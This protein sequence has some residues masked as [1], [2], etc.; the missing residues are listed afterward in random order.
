[1]PRGGIRF[2][3]SR[4]P[5]GMD[6]TAAPLNIEPGKMALV[7]NY[8][9]SRGAYRS[10]SG[11][12][13]LNL[14][15]LP[16]SG[17][18]LNGVDQYVEVEESTASLEFKISLSNAFGAIDISFIAEKRDTTVGDIQWLYTYSTGAGTSVGV[19]TV[20]DASGFLQ[21]GLV[22]GASTLTSAMTAA[23]Q[24]KPGVGYRVVA[25]KE[26]DVNVLDWRLV[27][28]R[29]GEPD[30]IV[31]TSA[32]MVNESTGRT[33]V[34]G[35][36]LHVGAENFFK[37]I[38]QE[39]RHW[40]TQT[41]S[42]IDAAFE[43]TNETDNGRYY[44]DHELTEAEVVLFKASGMN[45]YFK[46]D[47]VNTQNRVVDLTLSSNDGLV[48]P[49]LPGRV[50]PGLVDNAPETF[51]VDISDR[52]GHYARLNERPA[53]VGSRLF[54]QLR[55]NTD[56]EFTI[57]MAI[58]L[59]KNRIDE[60]ALAS[61]A[62]GI[63]PLFY[64]GDE[65][66]NGLGRD[67]T[68]VGEWC[69]AIWLENIGTT[70]LPDYRVRLA[71]IDETNVRTEVFA[72]AHTV[73]LGVDYRIDVVRDGRY[74]WARQYK[75]GELLIAENGEELQADLGAAVG[76]R[77]LYTGTFTNGPVALV[78]VFDD[79]ATEFY[80]PMLFDDIRMYSVNAEK[81][82]AE[83]SITQHPWDKVQAPSTRM[84][85]HFLCNEPTGG[86]L[87]D[88][89]PYN[90]NL[91][92]P[93]GVEGELHKLLPANTPP[94]FGAGWVKANRYNRAAGLFG[95]K[96]IETH[97]EVVFAVA[98]GGIW[99]IS[100]SITGTTRRIT[101]IFHGLSGNQL[102]R[103]VHVANQA[104]FSDGLNPVLRYDGKSMGPIGIPAPT[105]APGLADGG[106]VGSGLLA[107]AYAYVFT[108]KNSK[109]GGRSNPSPSASL[110][111]IANTQVN[112][113]PFT[114]PNEDAY[115]A[116]DT[117]EIWRTQANSTRLYRLTEIGIANRDGI[118]A[119]A[120]AGVSG[121]VLAVYNDIARDSAIGN[122]L[123][124]GGA[125][126]TAFGVFPDCKYVVSARS[127]LV[128]IA[129]KGFPNR[130]VWCELGFPDHHDEAFQIT[131]DMD[132][133][134]GDKSTGGVF[135]NGKVLIFQRR[136]IWA[137]RGIE[138]EDTIQIDLLF[139]G[140]GC[141]DQSTIQV[142]GGSVFFRGED[143]FYVLASGATEPSEIGADIKALLEDADPDFDQLGSSAIL[144]HQ[145]TYLCSITTKTATDADP[146]ARNDL[147]LAFTFST[148][149]WS[150]WSMNLIGAMQ[151]IEIGNRS[152]LYVLT[153][154]GF[155]M[156]YAS[157]GRDVLRG[158]AGGAG[159]IGYTD[160]LAAGKR[161][162]FTLNA[163]AADGDT[164]I[165]VLETADA[166]TAGDGMKGLT[167]RLAEFDRTL[168]EVRTVRKVIALSPGF[169]LYLDEPITLAATITKGREVW[170]GGFTR[171][172][173]TRDV[174]F[175]DFTQD[176]EVQSLS[177]ATTAL[178][179]DPRRPSKAPG[180]EAA[181]AGALFEYGYAYRTDEGEGLLSPIVATS[182]STLTLTAA[183]PRN[184]IG[185]NPLIV[186][187]RRD[188]SGDT[189]FEQVGT[190]AITTK[191][192]GARV[193]FSDAAGAAT[194]DYDPNRG[195]VLMSVSLTRRER[196]FDTIPI[197]SN[198]ARVIDLSGVSGHRLDVRAKGSS[199]RW[200]F[201]TW[202]PDAAHRIEGITA[203]L[204]PQD[205]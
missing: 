66:P 73:E 164:Y 115:I 140:V 173:T 196:Q 53:A 127:R 7:E 58:R 129:P 82:L 198:T 147:T 125:A 117:I 78:G 87:I 55:R 69:I 93:F 34:I 47:E 105:N 144:L 77:R 97:Q 195:N 166:D 91:S 175:D 79:G 179:T 17:L 205:Q 62:T 121:T 14:E 22:V 15:A 149:Q 80:T 44:W 148:G 178:A 120:A 81:L 163:A 188:V 13:K 110:T 145:S 8:D 18:R 23:T 124:R 172:I 107:G 201:E 67:W 72:G 37:G 12:E 30:P 142:Y 95:Y 199:F 86:F 28:W 193:S 180:I 38:V 16:K 46:L 122:T 109:T 182:S 202:Y 159:A 49:A 43:F 33:P 104:I 141:V 154:P 1:M 146:N 76:A 60:L 165:D 96:D 70:S 118:Q 130:L 71:I 50:S 185:T 106:V 10:R 103:M 187:Y 183:Q 26:D 136:S 41:A 101:P 51:A 143:N 19:G 160:G 85:G 135:V 9:L 32:T 177:M 89:S 57:S 168:S 113:S 90:N 128:G 83:Q 170:V 64:Y 102:M 48:L 5:G 161:V 191:D 139:A 169:R 184:E 94:K 150:V 133:G 171:K 35:R 84:V 68:G 100:A 181:D 138:S 20:V 156:R 203:I 112:V 45:C 29:Q 31:D 4:Q 197:A 24:I 134:T 132:P 52:E 192:P 190:V 108:W 174:S 167:V 65:G 40:R 88:S 111:V 99:G 74:V 155:V 152:D 63:L 137:M 189:V 123:L 119:G 61:A 11:L 204:K 186:F 114:P 59:N 2:P 25:L 98:G 27:L 158:D 56:H 151:A 75:D 131:D 126:T 54:D 153:R 36:S 6:A 200:E 194:T 162:A 116:V 176:K 3:I 39:F 92:V 157:R 21:I 42:L